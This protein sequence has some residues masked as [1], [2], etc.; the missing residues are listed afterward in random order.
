MLLKI[1]SSIVINSILRFYK[2][3]V[4]YFSFLLPI[5]CSSVSSDSQFSAFKV[6]AVLLGEFTG[7]SSHVKSS[8]A[9]Q[10]SLNYW[11]QIDHNIIPT[12][13]LKLVV[14]DVLESHFYVQITYSAN[15]VL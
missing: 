9:C 2:I 1:I 6:S 14:N 11:F 8:G 3:D 4:V 12:T 15:K 13:S 5:H 7:F 10:F